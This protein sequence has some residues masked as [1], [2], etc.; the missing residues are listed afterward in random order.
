MEMRN[1]HSAVS[2]IGK[3]FGTGG[4]CIGLIYWTTERSNCRI[5]VELKL[6]FVCVYVL[7][8]IFAAI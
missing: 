6:Y 8:L 1:N 4:I 3:T 7:E 5:D 2:A